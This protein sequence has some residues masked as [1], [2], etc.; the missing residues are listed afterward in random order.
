MKKYLVF[1]LLTLLAFV[2][3]EE[4]PATATVAI[5]NGEVIT[6]EQL[7]RAADVQGL[8]V[9]ISQVDQRFFNVLANTDEGVKLIL[10]YK[11]EVL[12]DLIDKLLIVQFAEKYGA[13]PSDEEVKK[14]VDNQISSYL[15]EQGIDEETFNS[16]LAYANMGTLDDFK[17]KMYFDVLVNLSVENLFEA[18]TSG[19]TID[20]VDLKDYYKDNVNEFLIPATYTLYILSFNDEQTAK[21]ALEQ[22]NQ[23][24][25]FEEIAS[26]FEIGQVKFSDIEE[27]A[28]FP[29]ELWKYIKKANKGEISDLVEINGN[30]Y[31][32][33]VIDSVPFKI[34]SFEE[35]KNEIYNT[36]LSQ[37]KSEIWSNFIDNEFKK[38]KEESEIKILYNVE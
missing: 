11:R 25:S 34:K 30:Y 6:L 13:R 5:V 14:I 26:N 10:R 8:M 28:L 18:V 15:K 3:A 36:L 29:E 24:K 23:G 12:N 35:A 2:F 22:L 32:F 31:I 16:Y 17:Q 9:N 20:E 37:K 1:I 27:D 4:L 33:E 21:K 19:V 7:N 38:F